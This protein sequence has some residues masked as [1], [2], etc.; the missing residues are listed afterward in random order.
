MD[1]VTRTITDEH[2]TYEFPELDSDARM[3]ELILYVANKCLDDPHFGATK[4][5]KV[6]FFADFTAYARTG[7]SITGSA[8]QRLPN[9]PA[10]K[11]LVPVRKSMVAARELYLKPQAVFDHLQHRLIPTRE[12]QLDVFTAAQIA[13]VDEVIQALDQM[14]A[15]QLSDLSHGAPWKAA[16]LG[17]LIPYQ[18][19]FLD[20]RVASES[21]I[22][23]THALAAERGWQEL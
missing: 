7:Q 11:R 6:L 17:G 8:Y 2:L 22:A 16:Q 5:N 23:E 1:R 14:T 15:S 9:G 13:L 4:L 3:R 20:D 19:V 21:E 18:A 10:P 12:P